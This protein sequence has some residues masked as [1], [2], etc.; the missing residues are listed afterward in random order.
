MRNSKRGLFDLHQLAAGGGCAW[1]MPWISLSGSPWAISA[2]ASDE[3]RLVG[4][5]QM[6]D[7]PYEASRE[8][9]WRREPRGDRSEGRPRNRAL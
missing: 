7:E 9:L 1:S 8:S 3:G 4:G 2:Q 5:G 6:G